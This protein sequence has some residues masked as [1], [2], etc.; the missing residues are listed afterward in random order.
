MSLYFLFLSRHCRYISY[1]FPDTVTILLISFQTLS[2]YFLFL[3]R[4]CH[5]TCYL[6][7]HIIPHISSPT[8]LIF[9]PFLRLKQ[10]ALVASSHSK[11]GWGDVSLF[12]LPESS[13]YRPDRNRS[14]TSNILARY[15]WRNGNETWRRRSCQCEELH[16]NTHEKLLLAGDVPWWKGKRDVLC[17]SALTI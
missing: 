12:T 11:C 4:H 14:D 7:C 2:L 17:E 1:F 16:L 3:S 13:R 6:K 8:L 15:R 9:H 10:A 5:Y